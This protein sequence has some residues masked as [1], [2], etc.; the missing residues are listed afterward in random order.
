MAKRSH[1]IKSDLQVVSSAFHCSLHPSPCFH[2]ILGRD[3]ETV[4]RMELLFADMWILVPDGAAAGQDVDSGVDLGLLLA[5][6]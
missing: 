3:V 4:A 6:M 1:L 5:E 2:I